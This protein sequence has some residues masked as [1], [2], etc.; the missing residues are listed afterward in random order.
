MSSGMEKMRNALIQNYVNQGVE[1]EVAQLAASASLPSAAGIKPVSRRFRKKLLRASNR[2]ARR[3][4]KA[5]SSETRALTIDAIR[6]HRDLAV[7]YGDDNYR[8][9]FE[10]LL[11]ATGLQ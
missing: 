7:Q 9:Y 10:E 1:P 8:R 5:D 2:F 11:R 3:L 6:G 4:R